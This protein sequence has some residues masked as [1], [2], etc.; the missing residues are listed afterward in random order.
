M[1]IAEREQTA[2]N[3]YLSLLRSNGAPEVDLEERSKLIQ[4]LLPPLDGQP[5]EG[6]LYRDEVE[7]LLETLDRSSWP[8]FLAATREFYYFWIGDLKKIA[9]MLSEG[10]FVPDEQIEVS[11]EESLKAVWKKLDNEQFDTVEM[12]S[13]NAYLAALRDEGADKA[14]IETRQKLIKLLMVN[15]RGVQ[16]R[17]GR[18]F[19]K[20]V[21]ALLPIFVMKETR[22]L[23][24]LVSREYYH[25]WV[26]DPD[27]AS[28][29]RLEL[30]SSSL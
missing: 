20:A 13:L 5:Q 16:E 1:K 28:H 9:A 12:W 15:L 25:F 24:L 10:E 29:I 14:L 23:F 30:Q 4:P 11:S 21:D 27:A 6:W 26:G 18:F 8:L 22:T 19:R 2:L 7:T 17:Q 3:A